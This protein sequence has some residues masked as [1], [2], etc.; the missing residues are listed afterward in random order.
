MNAFEK[1]GLILLAVILLSILTFVLFCLIPEKDERP[2]TQQVS[3]TVYEY[4]NSSKISFTARMVNVVL[5]WLGIKKQLLKQAVDRD[6]I[7]EPEAVPDKLSEVY[8]FTDS[9]L[10]NR[11]VWIFTPKNNPSPKVILY[12]HG[13]SYTNNIASFQWDMVADLLQKTNATFVVQDYPLAP[14]ATYQSAY[15]FVESVYNQILT[16]TKPENIILMGD[17][18]GGGLAFGFAQKLRNENRPQPSQIILLSPWLDITMSNPVVI[19]VDKIDPI[20]NVEALQITGKLYAGSI[21]PTNYQVSPIYGQFEDLGKLSL[22]IGTHDVF[23]GDNRKLNRLLKAHQ[24][25][26]NYYEYPKMIHG[27]MS[28]VRIPEAQTALKQIATLIKTGKP[29]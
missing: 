8:N 26:F 5:P 10:Q 2:S 15:S 22:F 29:I 6:F 24:I 21:D 4:T 20:L 23:I 27:W 28:F 12:V 14:D 25:P 1:I 9:L 7:H 16:Q 11:H 13:G 19:E 3:S 18:A 17:S